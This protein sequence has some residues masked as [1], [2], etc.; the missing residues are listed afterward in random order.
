M[1]TQDNTRL[2]KQAYDAFKRG[3]IS[4]VLGLFSD[5]IEWELDP[6]EN[7]PFSGKRKGKEQVAQFFQLL[8]ESQ[9]ML[10]FEPREFIAEGDKVVALGHYAWSV[11][12]TDRT[13]ESDWVEVFTLQD[14]KV[15][16]F[17]EYADTEA[18][19]AAYKR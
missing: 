14:G 3:D 15:V 2:V 5:D 10:Q 8:Q 11:R 13:F 16:R 1:S 18:A 6:V 4:N 7:A 17:R 9:E 19:T 12:S